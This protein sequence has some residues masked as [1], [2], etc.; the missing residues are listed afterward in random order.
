MA[1][2][3]RD[4]DWIHG[5]S[6]PVSKRWIRIASTDRDGSDAQ[7]LWEKL[8]SAMKTT[9]V[10]RELVFLVGSERGSNS[11]MLVLRDVSLKDSRIVAESLVVR[12]PIN[13]KTGRRPEDR[14]FC[15]HG[16]RKNG[17]SSRLITISLYKN[18]EWKA[19]GLA[20]T[21]LV[22][23]VRKSVA[24]HMPREYRWD[25]TLQYLVALRCCIREQATD[26]ITLDDYETGF[27][28]KASA[29]EILGSPQDGN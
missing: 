8:L 20:S 6:C 29:V 15:F 16:P 14:R 27:K 28:T 18:R 2:V 1:Q 10:L 22:V 9:P 5:L 13:P 24:K 3:C 12:R 26:R 23:Q 7:V 25:E 17:N 11:S 21:E 4:G 19:L